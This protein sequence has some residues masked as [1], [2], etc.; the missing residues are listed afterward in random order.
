MTTET[1]SIARAGEGNPVSA[2]AS[3][4]LPLAEQYSPQFSPV[5]VPRNMRAT[6]HWAEIMLNAGVGLTVSSKVAMFLIQQASPIVAFGASEGL[7]KALEVVRPL[8]MCG[9]MQTDI[10]TPTN[11]VI[12]TNAAKASRDFDASRR[13]TTLVSKGS[14]SNGPLGWQCVVMITIGNVATLDVFWNAEISLEWL[15]GN[16]SERD[17]PDQQVDDEENCG[18]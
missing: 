10:G 16:G 11:L 13:N 2:N 5:V 14:Q 8:L 3:E 17:L 12:I 9:Q 7:A 6:M 1:W 15:G 18:I 4:L